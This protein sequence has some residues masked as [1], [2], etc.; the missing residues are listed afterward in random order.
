MEM[1]NEK[2]MKKTTK[3]LMVLAALLIGQTVA[4]QTV[5]SPNVNGMRSHYQNRR[6]ATADADKARDFFVVTC[7]L[8]ASTAAIANQM[9]SLGGIIRSLLANQVLVELPMSQL[10]AAAAIDGVLLIDA[11]SDGSPKTDKSRKASH[12]DEVHQ[13]KAEGQQDLPQ[14]YTGKG[15]II[16]LIDTGY[17]YTHPMFKDNN[18]NLRIKGVYRPYTMPKY[19][20]EPLKDIKVTDEKGVTT[21]I[22]LTGSFVT[23]P[24]VILDTL[25]IKNTTS[26]HGTHCA[27]I[28]AGSIMDYTPTFVPRD[29]NSGKLGGMAPDAELFLSETGVSDYQED[30]YGHLSD[31]LR[32]YN[33]LQALYAMKHFADKQGKPLVVSI[34]SNTHEGLHDG[35]STMARYIGND[36]KEG[37]LLALC[38]SNEADDSIYLTRT[39]TRGN[40]VSVWL[41]GTA[42]VCKSNF[43]FKTDK[44]IKVDLAI[45]DAKKNI[46]MVCNLPLTSKSTMEYERELGFTVSSAT[47]KYDDNDEYYDD[48]CKK[49]CDY[50]KD[51]DLRV[52]INAGGALDKNYHNI[53]NVHINFYS[54]NLTWR[55]DYYLMLIISSPESDVDM[56]GWGEDMHLYANSVD[57]PNEFQPGTSDHSM[58][59]WCTSGEAVVVGAYVTDNRQM[60]YDD[61]W[62]LILTESKI[63]K[64]GKVTS[65]SSYGTDFSA[66]HLAYPDVVAPGYNIYAAGNSFAPRNVYSWAAYSDQFMGQYEPRKYP[67]SI[68][69]GTSMATPAAAG[70]I[71]LW[72]QAAMDKGKTLTNKD[73]KDIIRHSS[74][75][76]E[77]TQSD[78]LRYGAGK[79]NAY[80]GLLYVL[81]MATS[82]PEL[83]TRHIAATL[84]GRTLHI[85][86]G[87]D[88]QVTIY[89]LSGQ[90]VLDTRS[91]SGIV[92]LPALPAGVYAVKIG[93]LGSTLIRL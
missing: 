36:C 20:S 5:F 32:S 61:D 35:T 28:A 47:M 63:E 46:I 25:E 52:R 65:Y 17:D 79:I 54:S 64:T 73:I 84:Q 58:G 12:V 14:A 57:K 66:D 71:A 88:T 13:G 51:G 18:D 55:K 91:A 30:T 53:P 43:F 77:W 69:G 85:Q 16:G 27:S 19:Y 33:R 60:A 7:S 45:A 1:K 29:E 9:V 50:I 40:S 2:C 24:D 74:E 31:D 90:K 3:L 72:V 67:Y 15:V 11:P 34:S 93:N 89:N 87:Q 81:G 8:E 62:N 75:Q 92:E 78:P 56:Q 38:S 6:A 39:I 37:N 21:A 83:P 42:S 10:D 44:E 86:G 22:S 4:A 82:V 76:D 59:D 26:S 49:L 80:K 68:M 70:I 48:I 23:D 41:D